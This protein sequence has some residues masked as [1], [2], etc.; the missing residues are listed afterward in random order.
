[1]IE[2]ELEERVVCHVVDGND[3]IFVFLRNRLSFLDLET[4]TRWLKQG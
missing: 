4:T 2:E 1:M 3:F